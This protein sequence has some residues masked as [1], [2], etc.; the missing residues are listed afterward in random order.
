MD[1]TEFVRRWYEG[2]VENNGVIGMVSEGEGECW[3][4]VYS[5]EYGDEGTNPRLIVEYSFVG[6]GDGDKG[7]VIEANEGNIAGDGVADIAV[8]DDGS[9]D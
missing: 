1:C 5:R 3:Y 2:E 9:N 8:G 4:R 7:E 6:P